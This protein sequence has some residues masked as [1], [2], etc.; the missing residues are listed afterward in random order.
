MAEA[1]ETKQEKKGGGLLLSL[2][3][4]KVQAPPPAFTRLAGSAEGRARDLSRFL[5]K[6]VLFIASGLGVLLLAPFSE[7]FIPKSDKVPRMSRGFDSKGGLLAAGSPFEPG[8]GGNAPGGLPGGPGRVQITPLMASD[9]R[10]MIIPDQD[11][12]AQTK[13]ADAPAAAPAEPPKDEGWG[14]VA[15]K[16]ATR[17]AREAFSQ[18]G[19]P[20]LK[21]A[22]SDVV[23]GL[24]GGGG[25]S[26]QAAYNL[27][28]I[29]ARG[30]PYKGDS[31]KSYSLASA[32]PGYR[33][34]AMRSLAS[35]GNSF[36]NMKAAAGNQA[37]LLNKGT[38]AEALKAAAD[39]AAKT[40]DGDLSGKDKDDEKKKPTANPK[41]EDKNKKKESLAELAAKMEMQK[42]VELK[43]K[44]KE[45]DEL[46]R[47]KMH[48]EENA[49]GSW[50][51][52]SAQVQANAQVVSAAISAVA[53]VLSS[54]IGSGKGGGEEDEVQ[55]APVQNQPR[56]GRR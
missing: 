28:P 56:N 11:E 46:G 33:S 7:F 22:L 47:T 37:S 51:L 17:G 15:K 20:R 8:A 2:G 25:G 21:S 39:A 23:K 35:S 12:A 24:S 6:D 41:D 38:A 48:E 49:K 27:A 9:P 31:V 42:Q 45:W 44:K 3:R 19:A 10:Q 26:T 54:A 16:A 30:V 32:A 29:S 53:N 14:S 52:K 43:W 40:K 1:S 50:Q 13:T 36:D 4:S 34:V 18:A 5:R 55:G